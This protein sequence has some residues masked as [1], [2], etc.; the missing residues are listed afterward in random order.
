MDRFLAKRATGDLLGQATEFGESDKSKLV[1][2]EGCGRYK[3]Q[4]NFDL[5]SVFR[6]TRILAAFLLH[7]KD[8]EIFGEVNEQ[9]GWLRCT[10]E[11]A[12][13]QSSKRV[14]EP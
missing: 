1:P 10:H 2:E 9:T 6:F 7:N 4:T 3:R 14:N 5:A 8:L 13:T 11:S 12:S